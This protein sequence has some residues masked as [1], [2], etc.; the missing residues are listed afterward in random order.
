MTRSYIKKPGVTY[1][2]PRIYHNHGVAQ[3]Y[4]RGCRCSDCRRAHTNYERE[5]ARNAK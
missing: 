2:R 4:W 5:R 3:V 1:G